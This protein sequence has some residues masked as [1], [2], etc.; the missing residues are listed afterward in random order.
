MDEQ[1]IIAGSHNKTA[2]IIPLVFSFSLCCFLVIVSLSG[3]YS[4][5][6]FVTNLSVRT[7]SVLPFFSDY[8]VNSI[9]L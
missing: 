5:K 4:M 6:P 8:S 9:I 2:M 3:H 1:R 7:H